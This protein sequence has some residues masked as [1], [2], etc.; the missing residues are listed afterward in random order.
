MKRLN[1]Y[2]IYAAREFA[3]VNQL[4]RVVLDS[5]HARLGIITTGKAYLDV[6]QALD[7]M[8]INKSIAASIGIRVF[9]VAMPWPLEPQHTHEFAEGLEEILVV[10]EKRSIIED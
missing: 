5:P 6:M 7:D 8:G 3:R 1:K 9:K 2:K 10:E 4:N